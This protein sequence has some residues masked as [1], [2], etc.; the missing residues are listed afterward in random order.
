MQRQHSYCKV[1]HTVCMFMYD[2]YACIFT[3]HLKLCSVYFTLDINFTASNSF[4]TSFSFRGNETTKDRFHFMRM[5][6]KISPDLCWN[7]LVCAMSTSQALF[8]AFCLHQQLFPHEILSSTWNVCLHTLE[9]LIQ[10]KLFPST[11]LV[12]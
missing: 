12:I 4:C 3:V 8:L 5:Q 10:L 2:V 7:T 1:V 6:Y 11:V 9:H